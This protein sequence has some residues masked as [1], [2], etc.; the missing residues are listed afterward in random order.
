MKNKLIQRMTIDA[1]FIALIIIFTFVPFLG[2]ITVGVVS[3]TTIHVLVILGAML[4]GWKEGLLFGFTFGLFSLIKAASMPVS[5]GDALFLNP[6][7]S[8]MPRII[9]GGVSGLLFDLI[10]KIKEPK[11]VFSLTA[12]NAIFSCLLHT[13][14]TVTCM[15]VFGASIFPGIN[16]ILV[17]LFSINGA[18][19]VGISFLIPLVLMVPLFNALRNIK[20]NPFKDYKLYYSANPNNKILKPYRKDMLKT[21]KQLVDINSVYDENSADE[22][23]PFGKGVSE[24]LNFVNELAIKDGFTSTNYENKIVEIIYGEGEKNITIMAHAD[25][26]PVTGKTKRSMFDMYRR[27]FTLYGRGVSDDKG[28]F[29]A[30]Y[31]ALKALKDNNMINGYKVRLLVGGNEESGSLGMHH[32]FNV[33]KK[34]QPTYGFSPDS[35]FPLTHAEK[36]IFNFVIEGDLDL[37]NIKSIKGGVAANAVIDDVTLI[38]GDESL[39]NDLKNNIKDI[40]I[41]NGNDEYIVHVFGKS[42]HGSMPEKGIN[43]ALVLFENLAKITN[44]P[45]FKD[46]LDKIAPTNA[47]GLKA[48]AYSDTMGNNTLNLG[49][50]NYENNHISLVMNYRFVDGVKEEILKQNIVESLKD[51]D[52]KFSPTSELLYYPLDHILVKTLMDVYRKE[53]NDYTSRPMAIGGG[54]YAKEANNVLAFGMQFPGVDT[55]MHE[56]GEFLPLVALYKGASIYYSAILAL[57]DLIKNEN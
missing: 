48:D 31:Y 56:S 14:I 41:T 11:L 55:K 24:A 49:F 34:E 57:G 17:I 28:P 45:K 19:E 16:D 29:V 53:T 2:Y 9:F 4:F 23:N 40:N 35:D 15:Y 30:S 47:S 50:I 26:V 7:I 51:Y 46:F 36:G 32:Y 37:G 44:N 22:N 10:K 52:V 33:L 12:V 8:I 38:S 54:T 43:A 5:A 6:L 20:D 39:I 3:I 1:L 27:N 25:V 18:I 13:V 42:A 21:L